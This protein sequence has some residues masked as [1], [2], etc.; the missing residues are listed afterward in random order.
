MS[1][2]PRMTKICCTIKFSSRSPN[3]VTKSYQLMSH[4]GRLTALKSFYYSQMLYAYENKQWTKNAMCMHLLGFTYSRLTKCLILQGARTFSWTNDDS[5][6][7]RKNYRLVRKSARPLIWTN[8]MRLSSRITSFMKHSTMKY[9]I[10][11][12]KMLKS[13]KHNSLKMT[14]WSTT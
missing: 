12:N 6:A 8:F 1:G 7:Q 5:K 4:H 10:E 13:K 9:R 11:T 2:Q 14:D 3:V